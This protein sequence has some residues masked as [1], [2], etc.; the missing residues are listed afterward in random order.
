MLWE[1]SWAFHERSK[2]SLR[3]D[4]GDLRS[5]G[6]EVPEALRGVSKGQRGLQ[7]EFRGRLPG[8][9]ERFRGSQEHFKK[10]RLQGDPGTFQVVSLVLESY[11]GF[12]EDSMDS[13]GRSRES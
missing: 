9:Q 5:G 1:C 2:V 12:Q 11:W 3:G 13:Q 10:V 6:L 8:S 7:G 4:L